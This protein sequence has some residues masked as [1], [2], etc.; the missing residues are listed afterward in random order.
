VGDKTASEKTTS[1]WLITDPNSSVDEVTF[2]VLLK[3]LT[4]LPKLLKRA[5]LDADKD[6]EHVHRLRVATRR[7]DAALTEFAEF[8]EPRRVTRV[9]GILR[10]LRKAAGQAR[11]LDVLMLANQ[12]DPVVVRKLQAKRSTAQMRIER[13]YRK[14]AESGKLKKRIRQ[15]LRSIPSDLVFDHD[16]TIQSWARDRLSSRT[17]SLLV[18]W[19]DESSDLESLHQFRIKAKALRYTIELFAGVFPTQLKDALYPRVEQIQDELGDINDHRV[20]LQNIEQWQ[21]ETAVQD[22]LLILKARTEAELNRC[23]SLFNRKHGE[24]A[25]EEFRQMARACIR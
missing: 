22:E 13:A 1:K 16:E 10:K 2:A 19:P 5:A 4:P 7:A 17:E 6:I 18:V 3:R 12:D 11:D 23:R 21:A 9:A 14:H 8:L 24:A 25:R 15:L 20:A